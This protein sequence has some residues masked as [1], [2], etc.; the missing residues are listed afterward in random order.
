M[1]KKF[2]L[3][4]AGFIA[5][6]AILGAV[7]AAQIKKLASA[8]HT[9]PP[10]AVATA[11]AKAETWSSTLNS[12][13]TLAPVEGVLLSSELEGTVVKIAAENGAKVK[14]G[15]LLVE[16]DTS[17]ERP[18]LAAAEARA[19]LARLGSERTADLFGRAAI[20][21]AEFDA[22][23][24]TFKQAS[25]EVAALKATIAK[26]QVRAPFDGRVG[27]RQVNLGQYVGR[28]ATLL[29]L[30][31]LDP[32]YVNFF[33]PQRF[34]PVVQ[35]GQKVT[36]TF[37]AFGDQGF[38]ATITAINAEVDRA[39]RNL[40][41]QATAANP[42]ERLRAGM[43]ARVE[44]QL[45]EVQAVVAV[46]ATAIAYASYGNS[47]FVVEKMKDPSGHEYTGVRQ[48][49]V[50]LGPTRGDLIAVT[51]GLKPGEEVVTAGVFKLRNGAAVQVNNSVQPASNPAPKPANT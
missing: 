28:G 34:L 30:Q 11:P 5:V 38:S 46:P 20:S 23:A 1:L 50:K 49:F 39:S 19:E 44:V 15:D 29:P 42:D 25:A 13:G 27:L 33:V 17:V 43:F 31:K 21:K 22:A 14:A 9:M 16:F 12:I 24:A 36:L 41:V 26:K 4:I 3:A 2:L 47:V 7:K 32:V 10:S 8:P 51:E 6:V 18:Q 40:A 35:P 37:D 48:Q 45:P